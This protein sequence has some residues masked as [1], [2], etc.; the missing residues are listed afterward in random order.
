MVLLRIDGEHLFFDH[1]P[2]AVAPSH[3]A[4]PIGRRIRDAACCGWR[5]VAERLPH[6][7]NHS[8]TMDG[9]RISE[10]SFF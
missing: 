4:S 5:R 2:D 3:A 7:S 1:L 9:V 8:A 6:H 10:I